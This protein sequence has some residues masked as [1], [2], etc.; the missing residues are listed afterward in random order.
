MKPIR[1]AFAI[2]L[3]TFCSIANGAMYLYDRTQFAASVPFDN[4]TNGFTSNNV[5][6]A[7]E[8]TLTLSQNI[9]RFVIMAGFDGSGSTGRWLEFNS[10]VASNLSPFVFP[11]NGYFT[12]YSY[13]CNGSSTVTFGVYVNAVKVQ[14]LVLSAAQVGSTINQYTTNTLDKVSVK[15]E[16]GSCSKPVV[17]IFARFR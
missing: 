1:I 13:A 12:E 8:E 9:A 15:I 17:S 2:A 7:I 16:S 3:L 14:N 4:S 10:N 6:S 11:R 5:Q